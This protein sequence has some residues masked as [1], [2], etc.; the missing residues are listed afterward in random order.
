MLRN[1][2]LALSLLM[3]GVVGYAYYFPAI[4]TGP[5][6]SC[7]E[8]RSDAENKAATEAFARENGGSLAK[9]HEFLKNSDYKLR[10]IGDAGDGLTFVYVA[11]HYSSTCG[12]HLPGIDG[13]IVRIL[14]DS[15]VE[16][17]VKK[18]F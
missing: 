4:G 6:M 8:A 9:T 2:V 3:N 17:L 11:T 18:V 15:Q 13:S 14:T 1:V 12:F 10:N 16:P 7:D 5:K